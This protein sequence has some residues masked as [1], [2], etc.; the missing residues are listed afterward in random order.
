MKTP[1]LVANIV[2]TM[3]E[4]VSIPVTVKCR[5]GVDDL[6]SYDFTKQF[7]KIVAD[8]GGIEH[9]VVHARKAFL[10][11]LN[12]AENRNIPPL[13]Y[14]YGKVNGYNMSSVLAK[15]RFPRSSVFHQW[16]VQNGKLN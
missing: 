8:E 11:G 7:V 16:R 15:V 3:R 9:F 10:K 12:P 13:K 4:A 5:L 14:D 1:E 6:D 2:R